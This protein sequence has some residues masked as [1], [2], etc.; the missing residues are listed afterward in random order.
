MLICLVTLMS[1]A[2]HDSKN[3]KD[4][5]IVFYRCDRGKFWF[6]RCVKIHTGK[7]PVGFYLFHCPCYPVVFTLPLLL[8]CNV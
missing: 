1:C 6:Q 2:G 8:I 7:N 3:I 5:E 4:S